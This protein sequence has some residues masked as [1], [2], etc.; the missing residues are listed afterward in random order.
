MKAIVDM[1][2]TTIASMDTLLLKILDSAQASSA[3]LTIESIELRD[4]VNQVATQLQES[5]H[6]HGGEIVCRSSTKIGADRVLLLQLI[7]NLCA[8]SLKFGRSGVPPRIVIDGSVG[9]GG[10]RITLMDNGRG[11]PN[12]L[13]PSLFERFTR[14]ASSKTI[15]GKGLGLATCHAI[16]ERHGGSITAQ[17]TPGEGAVFTIVLPK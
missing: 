8:N 10:T 7:Q 11:F 16:V 6:R 3:P 13:G 17:G 4:C 1:A 12:E 2:D 9:E 15:E 5:L 14:M